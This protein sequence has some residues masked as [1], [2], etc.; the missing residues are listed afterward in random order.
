MY[1][2]LVRLILTTRD[3]TPRVGL[4]GCLAS[5]LRAT[6]PSLSHVKWVFHT[7]CSLVNLPAPLPS[8]SQPVTC[9]ARIHWVIPTSKQTCC[10]FSH[11]IKHNKTKQT[12]L[13][14]FSCQLLPH[15]FLTHCCGKTPQESGGFGS[16]FLSF[17]AI[18]N[19]PCHSFSSALASIIFLHLSGRTQQQHLTCPLL[20]QTPLLGRRL[21]WV[22]LLPHWLR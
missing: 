12:F 13:T 6:D 16:P 5:T 20:L 3:H 19:P 9:P 18:L 8:H 10:D 17:Q 21:I 11:L 15:F 1:C 4:E 2:A 14:R 22:F 7:S